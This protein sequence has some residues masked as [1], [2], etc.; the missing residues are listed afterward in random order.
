[1]FFDG[2]GAAATGVQDPDTWTDELLKVLVARDEDR[3][4]ALLDALPRERADDVVGFI[5]LQRENWYAVRV[6]DGAYPLHSTI[7]IGRAPCRER[8]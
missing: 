2:R 6:E 3:A 4:H 8:V 7:E 1:L 5:A